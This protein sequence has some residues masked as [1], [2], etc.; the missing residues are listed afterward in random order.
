MWDI[1][2]NRLK[3]LFK[4]FFYY[5]SWRGFCNCRV[6]S[7][8]GT[9]SLLYH[10]SYKN[11]TRKEKSAVNVQ[12]E[13][14]HPKLG[15]FHWLS[16][17]ISK[18]WQNEPCLKSSIYGI[19]YIR[20]SKLSNFI[21]FFLIGAWDF[22]GLKSH[23]AMWMKIRYHNGLVNWT[24]HMIWW[25]Q[26]EGSLKQRPWKIQ[27]LVFSIWR[28]TKTAAEWLAGDKLCVHKWLGRSNL[29]IIS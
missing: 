8:S 15:Y 2:A 25:S 7:S 19:H 13:I 26:S 16:K 9:I 17:S 21:T 28:I 24:F 6:N 5:H 12:N 23:S 1:Q 18:G 20:S 11:D 22:K 10:R 4:L 3:A 27:S 29:A 14:N